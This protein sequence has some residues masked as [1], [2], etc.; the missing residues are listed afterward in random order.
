MT[1]TETAAHT[2][3]LTKGQTFR[4]PV[5]GVCTITRATRTK[6]YYSSDDRHS[7]TTVAALTSLLAIWS[8]A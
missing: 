3:T 7:V 4:H 2:A 6:V 1:T 5:L 8:A